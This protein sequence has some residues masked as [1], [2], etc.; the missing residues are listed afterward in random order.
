MEIS[1]AW[2]LLASRTKNENTSFRSKKGPRPQA[3]N[4]LEGSNQ[5]RPQNMLFLFLALVDGQR[6]GGDDFKRYALLSKIL[7]KSTPVAHEVTRSLAVEGAIWTSRVALVYCWPTML[8]RRIASV[9][10]SR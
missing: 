3:R 8:F 9:S 1:T 10:V 4:K 6:V 5:S 7:L 2:T